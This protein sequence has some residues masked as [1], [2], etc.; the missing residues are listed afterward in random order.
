M[1]ELSIFNF[2]SNEVRTIEVDGE[3][4]FMMKDVCDVLDLK[5]HRET[6]KRL[7]DYMKV[8]GVTISDA[9][10]RNQNVNAI[11]E[12]GLYSLIFK[13][14]KEKAKAFQKWVFTEVLPKIRKDGEYKVSNLEK[15]LEQSKQITASLETACIQRDGVISYMSN[16]LAPIDPKGTASEV[17]GKPRKYLVHGYFRSDKGHLVSDGQLELFGT[18]GGGE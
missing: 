13:S 14:R 10:G 3:P 6:Y 7:D 17:N 18:E 4:V 15:E 11:N 12:F 5:Q 2:E 8:D 1:Q 16:T 9:L